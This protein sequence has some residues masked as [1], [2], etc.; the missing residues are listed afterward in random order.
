MMADIEILVRCME[1]FGGQ[2]SWRTLGN[3]QRKPYEINITLYDALKGVNSKV[4]EFQLERYLCA[5]AIM[6]SLEGVPAVYIHSFFGTENYYEGVTHTGQNRTINRYRWDADDIL[7]KIA[8]EKNDRSKVFNA[9]KR[10]LKIRTKQPAFHPNAVQFTLHI[11]DQVFGFWRQSNK[12]DQ[13]IFCLH[14]VSN[15]NVHI[16]LSSLNLISLDSWRDLTSEQVFDDFQA[17]D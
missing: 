4:D 10:L 7:S 12:R 3:N 13:S 17:H 2:I 15:E 5:H 6:F 1:T 8:D 14:N 11:S 9:M 16:P